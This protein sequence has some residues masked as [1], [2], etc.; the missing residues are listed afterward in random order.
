M[1]R[2]EIAG[3]ILALALTGMGLYTL[4]VEG[5]PDR[6]YGAWFD[7]GL[8]AITSWAVLYWKAPETENH[9]GTTAPPKLEP[10]KNFLRY[11]VPALFAVLILWLLFRDVP[12]N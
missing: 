6:N 5:N 9:D 7:I 1:D 11:S 10:V 12:L 2:F 8:A 3:L 4:L